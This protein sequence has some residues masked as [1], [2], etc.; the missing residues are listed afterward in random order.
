MELTGILISL[1]WILLAAKIGGRLAKRIGQPAVLGELVAGVVIG[2]SVLGLIGKNHVIEVFAEIGAIVLL[3]EA[4]IES[5]YHSFMKVKWWALVVAAAGVVFPFLFGYVFSTAS[6][7]SVIQSVFIGATLTATSIGITVRVFR[8]LG[9]LASREAQIVIGAAVVD[10]VIGLIILGALVGL[11][12]TGS[13]SL[14]SIIQLTA[15]AVAFLAGSFLVGNLA[16]APLLR[17]IHQL[18]IRGLLLVSAFSFCLV[19]AYFS[20]LVGLAPIVGAFAAGLILSRTEHQEY[21]C[22]RLKPVAV[23]FIPVF[24]VMMGAAVEVGVFNPFNPDNYGALSLAGLLFLA[25][26]G[27][28]LMSG[29]AVGGKVEKLLVGVGM[30]P[31]G[32]VGMIF[33]AYGLSH[34]VFD[35][36]LYAAVLAVVALTTFVTPPVLKRLLV[37]NR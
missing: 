11:V 24:F 35:R 8:D 20:Q 22:R 19:M 3:F 34:G 9:R 13:F 6:G 23:I 16:A 37:K 5:D 36:Q 28:K 4:G 10:D 26:V 25:A 27:G 1:F 31:R 15:I 29:L 17:F 33:A 32:E 21:V 7:L 12:S 18:R 30:V 2:S 14:P